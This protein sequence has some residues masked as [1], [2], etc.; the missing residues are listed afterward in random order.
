MALCGTVQCT[1]APC[2]PEGPS[3]AHWAQLPGCISSQPHMFCSASDASWLAC[4]TAC[5]SE[6]QHQHAPACAPSTC[7]RA[8]SCMQHA[9]RHQPDLWQCIGY[10]PAVCLD[11]IFRARFNMHTLPIHVIPVM[12]AAGAQ[13]PGHH[14]QRRPCHQPDLLE[15]GGEGHP[16]S[17]WVGQPD[18]D[19]AAAGGWPHSSAGWQVGCS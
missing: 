15:L 3:A 7:R 4:A 6:H 10:L 9:S 12:L 17:G 18:V 16:T 8:P 13:G 2:T 5:H 19:A 1:G 14:A 11:I